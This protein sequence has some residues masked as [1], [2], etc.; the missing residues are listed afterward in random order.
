MPF[1]ILF[2][3]FYF[4]PDIEIITFNVIFETYKINCTKNFSRNI[5]QVEDDIL[6]PLNAT[7]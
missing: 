5:K 3:Y 4:S 7:V 6:R 2:I 1:S